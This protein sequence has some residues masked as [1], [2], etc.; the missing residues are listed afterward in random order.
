MTIRTAAFRWAAAVALVPLSIQ[1]ERLPTEIFSVRE[2]LHATVINRIIADSRGFVW[3]PA[4]E[5]LARF[6]GSGFRIFTREDGLPPGTVRDISER[7]GGSYWVS[8]DAQLCLLDPGGT[9]RRFQCE[10]PKLGVIG[11]VLADENGLWC[12]TDSGLWKRRY[13]A[14]SHWELVSKAQPGAVHRILK[15]SRGDIWATIGADLYRFRRNGKTDRWTSADG[16]SADSGTA[17]AEASGSI[18][19]GSQI[20]LSR[21]AIDTVTGDAR[22]AE[23]FDRSR[24]LP[25]SYVVDICLWNGTVWATTFSGLARLLPSGRWQAVE[26]DPSIENMTMQEFAV[27]S[28]DSLWVG[29]DGGGAFRIP[30]SGFSSFSERDGLGVRSVWAIFGDEGGALMAVAKDEQHL[31]ISRFDG[32]RFREEPLRA[33]SGAFEFGWSWSHIAVHSRSGGWWLGTGNGLLRYPDRLNATPQRLGPQEGLPSD[34]NVRVFEDSRGAVWTSFLRANRSALYRRAPGV[35]RFEEMGESRGLRT[36]QRPSECA[37]AF[38]EDRT[39]HIWIGTLDEGVLRFRDG[40]LEHI[41]PSTGAPDQG[42]RSLLIDHAGRLWIGTLR[43]GLLRVDDPGAA[44][45][46][47]RAYTRQAGLASDSIT[48]LAED[49]AGRIYAATGFGIDRLDPGSGRIRSFGSADGV[50][51][52]E[53]R[54]AATDRTGSVWFGGDSGLLRLQPRDDRVEDPRVVVYSVRVNGSDRMLSD[55]GAVEPQ[56]LSLE[57]VERQVLVQF[58]GFRHDLLYQTK[59]SGIDADWTAPS[60]A[61]SVHYLAL[62]P[63]AYDL[64]IRAA[65][66]DGRVSAVPAHVQWRIVAPLWQRWWFLLGLASATGALL[67]WWHRSDLER[68]LAIERIRSGIATDLHD[69]IGA[70]LSRIAITTEA[71]KLQAGTA[72]ADPAGKLSEIAETARSLVEDMSDIVW[73]IDPRRDTLGDL[74]GRLRAFGFAI[75]E[76]RGIRWTFEAPEDRLSLGLTPGARRHLYLILKEALHNVARHSRAKSASLTIRFDRGEIRAQVADDGCGCDNRVTAGLGIR[77]MQSRA[78]ILGGELDIQ[79]GPEGGTTINLSFPLRATDA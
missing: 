41:D 13:G 72:G 33:P 9:G 38:A 23:R 25:S 70:S 37:I 75:L 2:G 64:A 49:R 73:S 67:F 78:K 65:S 74:A 61:R 36:P 6:D 63:G 66:P 59:L 57:S 4:D 58:G 29:T 40:K 76:P 55:F 24:G 56:E 43:R 3:M 5:G 68:R 69:H 60:T 35:T 39:G 48:A 50:P 11:T 47:F 51:V 15:D 30:S 28:R 71:L 77:S 7:P 52:R 46:S 1:A 22:I 79:S 54:V 27:D 31:S 34:G 45:P 53:F 20:D 44:V 19:A 26:L 21:F 10:S 42:V 17:L 32:Y 16:I 62:A 8:V 14:A 18:W 12:G